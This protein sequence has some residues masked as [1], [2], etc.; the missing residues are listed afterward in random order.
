MP[1]KCHGNAVKR[2]NRSDD[3]K[4]EYGLVK[5]VLDI[6]NNRPRQSVHLGLSLTPL[7]KGEKLVLLTRLAASHD[8]VFGKLQPGDGVCINY[9][10]LETWYFTS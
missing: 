9:L 10:R 6:P 3:S 5:I 8:R 7:R 2:P 4:S 1:N